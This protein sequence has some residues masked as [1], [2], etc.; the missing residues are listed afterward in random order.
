MLSLKFVK[1]QGTMGTIFIQCV[2]ISILLNW[3]LKAKVNSSTLEPSITKKHEHQEFKECLHWNSV[4][5][6]LAV[7]SR[8]SQWFSTTCPWKDYLSVIQG[9]GKTHISSSQPWNY[10]SVGL[11]WAAYLDFNAF[12]SILLHRQIW[13]SLKN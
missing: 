8:R 5:I 3:S 9:L 1:H 7:E 11:G 4:V 10:K 12:H 13:E 2:I 6:H